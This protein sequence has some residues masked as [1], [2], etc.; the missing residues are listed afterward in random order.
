M[1]KR[2]WLDFND[3]KIFG[4]LES[5]D[6]SCDEHAF[7][8]EK[9]NVGGYTGNQLRH[10]YQKAKDAGDE[11]AANLILKM[12]KMYDTKLNAVEPVITVKRVLGWNA[13]IIKE[14]PWFSTCWEDKSGRVMMDILFSIKEIENENFNSIE[15][16]CSNNDIYHLLSNFVYIPPYK[17]K[18][19]FT[20]DIRQCNEGKNGLFYR[21]TLLLR[22]SVNG[23]RVCDAEFYSNSTS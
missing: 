4:V 20:Y 23:P 8:Y 9:I 3:E 10:G 13:G 12:L 7:D 16:I 2:Q 6:K 22:E 15:S 19:N 11:K 21:V 17:D 14:K 1:T 18:V 5:G